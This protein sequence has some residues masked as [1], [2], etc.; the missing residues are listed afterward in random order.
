MAALS[1]FHSRR[2]G[3]IAKYLYSAPF[4]IGLV[5]VMGSSRRLECG[6]SYIIGEIRDPHRSLPRAP[7][8]GTLIVIALYKQL[9]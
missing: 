7:F 6:D 2:S 9:F 8:G 4:A 1:R 5:F 3:Q